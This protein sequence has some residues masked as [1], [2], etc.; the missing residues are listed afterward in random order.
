LLSGLRGDAIKFLECKESGGKTVAK[1]ITVLIKRI[2]EVS[3][4]ETP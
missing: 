4:L 1:Y 2:E 3:F